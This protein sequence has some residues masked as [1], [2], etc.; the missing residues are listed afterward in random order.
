MFPFPLLYF[1][2]E[3][4]EKM[5]PGRDFLQ[6]IFDRLD[7]GTVG[8]IDSKSSTNS[9]FRKG[10]TPSENPKAVATE[11]PEASDSSPFRK[12]ENSGEDEFVDHFKEKPPS[13][14]N[15]VGVSK[16]KRRQLLKEFQKRTDLKEDEADH[17]KYTGYQGVPPNRRTKEL[18]Y[19][20]GSRVRKLNEYAN[21]PVGIDMK[22]H[23]NWKHFEKARIQADLANAK[24]EDW[25]EALFKFHDE[26]NPKR[27]YPSPNQLHGRAM[28]HYQKFHD[29][30]Y[31]YLVRDQGEPCFQ[32]SEYTGQA[33]QIA[34][35]DQMV[36]DAKKV[37]ENT[38]SGTRSDPDEEFLETIQRLVNVKTMSLEYLEEY[39][40][41]LLEDVRNMLQR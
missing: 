31:L 14:V 16:R 11:A 4:L 22:N 23:K 17:H 38:V 5:E 13:C 35:Y 10:S 39:Q 19:M 8:G 30:K 2:L 12:S 6:S 24:Y 33:W 36:R 18:W 40:P 21:I 41:K 7:F 1:F 28:E 26:K 34:Y 37:A 32:P 3:E 9:Q 20:Y 25:L 15:L 27:R 29:E